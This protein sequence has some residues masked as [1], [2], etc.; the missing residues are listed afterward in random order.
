MTC[1]TDTL[2]CDKVVIYLAY[3]LTRKSRATSNKC[4]DN[5]TIMRRHRIKTLH[6]DYLTMDIA[7]ES[8]YILKLSNSTHPYI[9]LVNILDQSSLSVDGTAISNAQIEAMPNN[10]TVNVTNNCEQTGCCDR[11]ASLLAVENCITKSSITKNS[12]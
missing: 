11:A 12:K 6:F 9:S 1:Y 4:E 7:L 3:V 5:L 8:I 10:M 2:L